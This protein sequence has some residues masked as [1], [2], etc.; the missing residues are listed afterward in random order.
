MP[1]LPE[2]ETVGRGLR[3]LMRGKTLRKVTL[4]RKDLRTP[5][6]K[7]MEKILAG[8]RVQEIE[9]RAKYL[10]IHLSGGKT[11]LVH[12]GMSGRMA[13]ANGTT[14]DKHDHVIFE[15]RRGRSVPAK[16]AGTTAAAPERI[17]FN[18]P[19]RF[20]LMDVFDTKGRE[21]HKL[22]RHIG[23]EPLSK[24]L[25][26]EYLAVKF[27]GKK[28]PIKVALMDQRLIAGIGNIYACEVLFY[29][30]INPR[31]Q[32]GKL[33]ADELKKLVPAIRKVLEKSIACG[34]SSLRDYVQADGGLGHFQNEFAVYGR[35]GKRCTAKG[36]KG[37]IQNITQG[38]RSTFFCS[39]TQK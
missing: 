3:R 37:M 22:L 9:R 32:A 2:V 34:G 13:L 19:R 4:R 35:E 7:D 15:L 33:K 16:T 8:R 38:G 24:E 27:K 20:G 18:D 5:F 26:P 10:L 14:L 1:E 28:V 17:V 21:Q 25:T 36:C 29:A 23:I 31:K 30:G 11:L 12:L 6:P 39:E